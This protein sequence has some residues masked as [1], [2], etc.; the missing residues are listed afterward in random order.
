IHGSDFAIAV[1]KVI[2]K[3]QIL[4]NLTEIQKKYIDKLA[5]DLK[6]KKQEFFGLFQALEDNDFQE[7]FLAFS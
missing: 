6:T 4:N 5:D 1:I 2:L 7:Q 3:I